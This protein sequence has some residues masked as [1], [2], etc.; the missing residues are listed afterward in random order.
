MENKSQIL[1]KLIELESSAQ[2]Y[3]FDWPN[4]KMIV[5][6]AISECDEIKKAIE[7]GDQRD[8]QS[9]VGDLIHVAVSLCVFLGY[10]VHETLG[11]SY[12]KFEKRMK[13]VKQVAKEE[14]LE[15]LHGQSI[16][17]MLELWNKAKEVER[18]RG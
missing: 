3:G 5:D 15:S 4:S 12:D 8:I 14:G 2:K 17:F 6:H 16:E 13:F 1:E 9:E 18:S 11:N 7:S 10:D